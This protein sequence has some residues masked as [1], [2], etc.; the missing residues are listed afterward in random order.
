[1]KLLPKIFFRSPQGNN[2]KAALVFVAAFLYAF[3]VMV[4][5]RSVLVPVHY[6][7]SVGG[8]IPGDPSYYQQLA[9]QQLLDIKAEGFHVFQLRPAGSG[10]A[11]VASLAYLLWDDPVAIVVINATLHSVGVVALFWLLS[12][13]FG[14]QIAAIAV[15]PALLSPYSIIWFSQLNKDSFVF[16]G[17]MLFALGLAKLVKLS[18]DR[19]EE[20]LANIF[21]ASLGGALIGLV[22]P[23]VDL[24]L[25]VAILPVLVGSVYKARGRLLW[26]RAIGFLV[27]LLVLGS[28]SSGAASDRTLDDLRQFRV[29]TDREGMPT[30]SACLKRID[31]NSWQQAIGLPS[32]VDDALRVMAGQ[33][34]LVL[35][36]LDTE[37]HPTTLSAFVDGDIFL[38]SGSDVL[39]YLPRSMQIGVL[40]PWPNYWW[41]SIQYDSPFYLVSSLEAAVLYIGLLALIFF[42]G[43]T[44]S[45]SL[46]STVYL[47][48]VV[49]TAYGITTPFLGALYR[50]RYPWW[51]MLLCLG[52][53]SILFI[54]AGRS[55]SKG[56]SA[57]QGSNV[58][59]VLPSGQ[60]PGRRS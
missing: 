11:G 37:T 27:V 4:F 52:V 25:L 50:Y 33:R 44:K 41:L 2:G 38:A 23:Y 5:V 28:M 20:V 57:D 14:R 59:T 46:M 10:P 43:K 21:L 1:M 19:R 13:W 32:L 6:P 36:I 47:A 8:V 3:V 51:I 30:A 54:V 16:A 49:M 60:L 53:A 40:A 31:T 58:T 18:E 7:S 56:N 45:W 29:S 39:K 26:E 15:I 12:I 34:C 35:S 22:R 9:R 17:S 24:I 55:H 48:L 42:M